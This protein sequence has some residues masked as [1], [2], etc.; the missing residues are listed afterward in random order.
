[1]RATAADQA[2]VR[3]NYR[4]SVQGLYRMSKEEGI[5][6]WTRGIGPNAVRAVLMN[7]SQ[8]GRRVCDY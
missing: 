1:M 7:M 8:L 6:S 3:Y 5:A 2:S 4:N